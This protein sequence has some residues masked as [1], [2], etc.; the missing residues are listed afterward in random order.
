MIIRV[1]VIGTAEMILPTSLPTINTGRKLPR[2]NNPALEHLIFISINSE[3]KPYYPL[4]KK[5]LIKKALL[6]SLPYVYLYLQQ[7]YYRLEE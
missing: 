1:R 3:M 2:N 4:L 7:P 6:L 5:H